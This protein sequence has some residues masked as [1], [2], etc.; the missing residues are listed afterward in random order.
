[1]IA[2]D[3]RTALPRSYNHENW[4]LKLSLTALDS[5]SRVKTY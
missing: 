1:M 5:A 3:R 2:I 4:G